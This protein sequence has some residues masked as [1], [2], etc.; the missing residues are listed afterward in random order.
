MGQSQVKV[1]TFNHFLQIPQKSHKIFF[2]FSLSSLQS[3]GNFSPSPQPLFFFSTTSTTTTN[4]QPPQQTFSSTL[5]NSSNLHNHHKQPQNHYNFIFNLHQFS[6][7]K[8]STTNNNLH[9]FNSGFI[10]W[11]QQ[12]LQNLHSTLNTITIIIITNTSI[13][14]PK[15]K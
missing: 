1:H 14:R 8:P 9:H 5:T 12:H 10:F 4:F 15:L 2:F 3:R 7:T 13:P 11:H 6:I